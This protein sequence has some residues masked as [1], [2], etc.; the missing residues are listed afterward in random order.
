[1]LKSVIASALLVLIPLPAL[2]QLRDF[3]EYQYQKYE[4]QLEQF[5]SD[6]NIP[7][8]KYL[9]KS[10]RQRRFDGRLTCMYLET[11]TV[12]EYLDGNAQINRALLDKTSYFKNEKEFYDE[13]AYT[14]GVTSAAVDSLCTENRAGL[15]DF[16][17]TLNKK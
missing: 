10:D 7:N 8:G 6:P 9:R 14:L 16:M 13:M 17:D 11:R 5:F 15:M 1:M 4:I 2:A 3:P 12:K